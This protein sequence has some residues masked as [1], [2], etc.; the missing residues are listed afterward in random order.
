MNASPTKRSTPLVATTTDSAGRAVLTLW[1]P[2]LVLTEA[3]AAAFFEP[4]VGPARGYVGLAG[5]T[6]RGVIRAHGAVVE[7]DSR[8]SSGTSVTVRFP[9]ASSN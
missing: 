6:A 7:I 8:E 2:E 4:F 3:E 9:A 5:A 1:A